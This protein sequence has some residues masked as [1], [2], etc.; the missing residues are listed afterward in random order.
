[1]KLEL[2]NHE[3]SG[4]LDALEDAIND[5]ETAM[6]EATPDDRERMSERLERYVAL[7]EKVQEQIYGQQQGRT[8]GGKD[9]IESGTY[10]EHIA[11][12]RR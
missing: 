11:K 4:L 6:R 7:D 10:D 5:A 1:M 12:Y 9:E 3:T 2:T 8:F